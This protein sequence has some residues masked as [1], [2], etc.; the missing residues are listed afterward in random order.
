MRLDFYNKIIL[1]FGFL[2]SFIFLIIIFLYRKNR[3]IN[4]VHLVK[5]VYKGFDPDNF[6]GIIKGIIWAFIDGIITGVIVALI[7]RIING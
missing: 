6:Q 5:T 1:S 4:F 3:L 7:I 2:N